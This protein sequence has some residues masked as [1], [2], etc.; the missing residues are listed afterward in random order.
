[1]WARRGLLDEP[2]G[3]Y[4]EQR[5]AEAGVDR[6]RVAVQRVDDVNHYTILVG[7]H[8]AGLVAEAIAAAAT[9]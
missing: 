3:L 4:D 9:P 8:G 1:M 6:E 5:L 2:R 7:A